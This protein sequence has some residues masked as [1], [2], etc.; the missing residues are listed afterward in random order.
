MQKKIIFLMPLG[1]DSLMD[2]NGL[3]RPKWSQVGFK[4]GSKIDV[5][6]NMKNAFGASPLMQNWVRGI[7]QWSK[8][9][10]KIDLKNKVNLGRHLGIDFGRF[11]ASTWSS[12]WPRTRPLRAKM[13]PRTS[14]LRLETAPGC[15][16]E[17]WFP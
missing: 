3:W 5:S 13:R 2:F 11:W 6:E 1:I 17:P 4:I 14:K 8:N 9:R 12:K 15:S 7:Q 16:N 10:T